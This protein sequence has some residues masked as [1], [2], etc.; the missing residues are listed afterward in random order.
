M[1]TTVEQVK[2]LTGYEVITE[3]IH[4][5]QMII[6]AYVG[7]TESEINTSHD[8]SILA[9]ATAYQVAYLQANKSIVFEQMDT[10]QISQMGQMVTF[11]D[12]GLSPWL[13]P[14]AVMTCQR[15]S[16]KRIR[17]I[18]TGSIFNEPAQES[19]WWNE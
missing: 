2:E 16:W 3:E 13:A 6:E 18:R 4:T 15:L 12:H 11:P 8:L 1:F 14:L 17:S 9:K 7:R 5:A 10:R 19:N